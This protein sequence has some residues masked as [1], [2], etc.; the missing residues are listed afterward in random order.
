MCH[1]NS[2]MHGKTD[3]HYLF[4]SCCILHDFILYL[5]QSQKLWYQHLYW[6]HT[7]NKSLITVSFPPSTT[8]LHL[9]GSRASQILQFVDRHL[10]ESQTWVVLDDEDV[11]LGRESMMMGLVR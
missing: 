11:T 1:H 2:V 7:L 8:V 4:I 5:A 9:D 10:D 6:S 3:M